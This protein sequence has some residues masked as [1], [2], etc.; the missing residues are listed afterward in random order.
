VLVA[1]GSKN[2]A[3]MAGVRAAFKSFR[4]A[5]F[6]AVDASSV[7]KPQPIGLED[8]V[9]GATERARFAKLAGDSD[10][11]VGVEAG[12]VRFGIQ[13]FLNLQV[14][15]VV[16]SSGHTSLGC[17]SGFPLPPTFVSRLLKE[18]LELDAYA[19]EITGAKSIR[20]EDGV[21]YHLTAGRL[22]RV[23]MTEQCVSMALVPWL[24]KRTYGLGRKANTESSG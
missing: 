18:G 4:G 16:D 22:S 11:G 2:P 3:K 6:V 8:T 19:H 20:E 7:A 12:V 23:E 9:H 15:A 10:Y 17:S 24:N 5:R 14:A 1:V 13:H 21:V